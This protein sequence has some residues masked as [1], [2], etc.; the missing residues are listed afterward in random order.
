[1]KIP[2]DLVFVRGGPDGISVC[3][4]CGELEGYDHDSDCIGS[5]LEG[6]RFQ[7]IAEIEPG[8][9][10]R[11]VHEE[12]EGTYAD[13]VSGL[14][15]KVASA[16]KVMSVRTFFTSPG[17]DNLGT[18]KHVEQYAQARRE[19]GQR[20]AREAKEKS[21][22]ESQAR[23]CETA[24]A[25]HRQEFA[26]LVSRREDFKEEAFLRRERE[27]NERH[28]KEFDDQRSLHKKAWEKLS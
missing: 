7:L 27:M 13:A 28:L 3:R 6:L 8:Y 17:L 4:W 15:A 5:L 18:E 16:Y 1:M 19:L 14:A 26:E 11:W 10:D 21:L 23:E 24:V 22:R 12:A 9:R 20:L 2:E 25:R